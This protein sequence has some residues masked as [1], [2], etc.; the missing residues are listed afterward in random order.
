M[1]SSHR[2]AFLDLYRGLIVVFMLEGHLIRQLMGMAWQEGAAFRGHELFHG[3]TAPGFLFG[4][5]FTFAIATQ[6]KSHLLKGLSWP[7]L[8]RLWR[9]ASLM[10][11]GYALHLPY[12][13]LS[14]T[15]FGASSAEWG[16]FLRFDVL[17]LIGLSL[18]ILRLLY[19]F[20]RDDRQFLA[21][22]SVGVLGTVMLAPA[23]WNGPGAS[24]PVW[25][26]TTLTG[27][28][29]SPFPVF[30]NLAFVLSGVVASW[31]F[32]RAR[33]DDAE[34]SY[35][36]WLLGAGVLFIVGGWLFDRLSITSNDTADYWTTAP[37][38]FWIRIGLLLV[39][40]GGLWFLERG[41]VGTVSEPY[42]M[43]RWLTMLGVESLFVYVAHLM[44]L[45][46]SV[47][48]PGENL[49]AW[50]GRDLTPWTAAALVVPFVV[51]SA[52]GARVWHTL[53]KRHGPL[54]QLAYWWMGLSF[55]GEMVL[56]AY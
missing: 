10:L 1:D 50:V 47:L 36:L 29:G 8:R 22:V 15:V 55:A 46:G 44:L 30:P 38:F 21:L 31:G 26:S 18:I 33:Q 12:L 39:G 51:L 7:V 9:G 16:A 53:K 42:L 56:R 20:A 43:P 11:V 49:T 24:A 32:L 2:Y 40:M 35:M 6:R 17:Q 23:V 5:G 28:Y 14:K 54:M 3:L 27:R 13:S 19:L 41:V 45:Y 4:A 37:S 48:N 25:L 34:H 52:I